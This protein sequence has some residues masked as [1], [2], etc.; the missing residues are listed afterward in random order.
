MAIYALL[1]RESSNRVFG[2]VAAELA[3][4]ELSA[5]RN[6]LSCRTS[7]PAV[8]EIA[9]LTYVRFECA[10]LSDRDHFILSNLALARG[11]FEII[12]GDLLRPL[13]RG[14]L[15]YFGS[16]L[17]TIQRYQG[18]T[19]EQFTHLLVNVTLASSSIA[20]QR[21]K[22]GERLRMLDPVAGRG[23]TLNR[24]LVYGFDVAG[25]EVDQSN[26]EQYKGFLGTYLKD[27]RIKHKITSE[28]FRKGDLAGSTSF[29]VRL[30]RDSKIKVPQVQ[31]VRAA[32]EQASSIFAKN[33]FELIVGDLPYG[34]AHRAKDD[35]NKPTDSVEALVAD[36]IQG[37]KTV[38]APGGA[39]G[40][41]WNVKS[42]PRSVLA[43]IATSA[44]LTVVEHDRS[45]V[46][47]VDRQITRDVFVCSLA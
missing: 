2:A 28:R 47:V 14:P 1:V 21:A 24:G 15:A 18:K 9:G 5:V 46:H 6:H 44:G 37:W 43:D 32:S 25:I 41:S 42:L 17:I 23:S 8:V 12:E 22:A 10:R 31:M 20:H 29:E 13:D 38:L 27:H 35:G 39:I 33:S 16:D 40:L 3:A 26:V 11:C 4:A 7:A 19:N 34:I 30:G 36:S 45:F